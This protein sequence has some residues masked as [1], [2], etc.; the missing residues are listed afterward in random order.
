MSSTA[1]LIYLYHLVH[2][3]AWSDGRPL[4]ALLPC[5][6]VLLPVVGEVRS[7]GHGE[8]L[9]CT[10]QRTQGDTETTFLS[11]PYSVSHTLDAYKYEK[12][13]LVLS[14]DTDWPD[15]FTRSPLSDLNLWR[16]SLCRLGCSRSSRTLVTGRTSP[17]R[18]RSS[19]LQ[20][21]LYLREMCGGSGI[22]IQFS[23]TRLFTVLE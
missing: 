16:H 7:S 13:K 6:M 1:P 5:C 11:S 18:E 3:L 15:Y 9:Q 22:L 14:E 19:G 2:P 4:D 20:R 10:D 21:C 8:R 23:W 12:Q 17:Q